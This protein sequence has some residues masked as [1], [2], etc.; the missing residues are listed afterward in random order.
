MP[1]PGRLEQVAEREAV[2]KNEEEML[3][4]YWQKDVQLPAMFQQHRRGLL[5]MLA[6]SE[7]MWYGHLGRIDISRQRS[8]LINYAVRP[9]HSA[10]FRT[11]PAAR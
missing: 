7:S 1:T 2:K 6:K 8:H 11:G 9:V 5:K 10:P 3:K 4:K